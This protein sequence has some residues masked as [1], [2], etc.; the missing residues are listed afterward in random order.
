[1]NR[2]PQIAEYPKRR[3][4]TFGNLILSVIIYDLT[5]CA[6][7][8]FYNISTNAGVA[9]HTQVDKEGEEG[10]LITFL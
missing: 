3:Q 1:M 2:S 6:I 5:T 7:L 10:N 4:A 8:N 9:R